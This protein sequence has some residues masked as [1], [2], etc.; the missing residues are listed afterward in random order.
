MPQWKF[1]SVMI[2]NSEKK[3]CINSPWHILSGHFILTIIV[4]CYFIFEDKKGISFVSVCC[5]ITVKK[6]LHTNSRFPVELRALSLLCSLLHNPLKNKLCKKNMQHCA[7]SARAVHVK[8][9][10]YISICTSN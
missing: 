10:S 7:E 3:T 1:P 2:T 4:L 8:K 6:H 5:I 9:I